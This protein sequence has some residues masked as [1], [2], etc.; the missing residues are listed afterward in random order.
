MSLFL[1]ETEI[2]LLGTSSQI[3]INVSTIEVSIKIELA[4]SILSDFQ[5]N[6]AGTSSLVS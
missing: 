5:V 2:N 6:P 4:G 3:D 1:R